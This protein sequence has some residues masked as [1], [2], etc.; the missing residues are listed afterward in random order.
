MN[1]HSISST[2]FL[3]SI[4][5]KFTV[6]TCVFFLATSSFYTS[7]SEAKENHSKPHQITAELLAQF[8]ETVQAARATYSVPGTAI[9]IVERGEIVYAKGF[10]WRDLENQLPV[11]PNTRF[12][13]GSITKSMTATMVATLVDDG[14]LDWKQPVVEIWPDFTLPNDELT[15]QVQVRHLMQMITGLADPFGLQNLYDIKVGTVSAEDQLESLANLPVIGELGNV[16][17]S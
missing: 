5:R 11:T 13:L 2:Q 15:Q 3:F 7:E 1:S 10:G 17:F 14:F 16:F 4:T 12:L 9:A 6:A 8:E